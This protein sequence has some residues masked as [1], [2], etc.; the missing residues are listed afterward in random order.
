MPKR[1]IDLD[2]ELLDESKAALGTTKITETV[3]AALR[4]AIAARAR[5]DQ[6]EYLTSGGL[7]SLTQ[8]EVREAVWQ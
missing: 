1:L 5:T 8:P 4:E 6:V 2:D 3:R 7:E